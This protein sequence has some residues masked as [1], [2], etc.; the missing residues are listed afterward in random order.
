MS[1]ARLGHPDFAFSTL[2]RP[3]KNWARAASSLRPEKQRASGG[4]ETLRKGKG[5]G[6]QVPCQA[7][8]WPLPPEEM[9]HTLHLDRS[10]TCFVTAWIQGHFLDSIGVGVPA[11]AES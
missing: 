10:P 6:K 11:S 3:P 7:A 8:T 4:P 1:A 2:N 9:D 5:L